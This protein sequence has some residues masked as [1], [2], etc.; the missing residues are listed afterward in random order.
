MGKNVCP[1]TG[2]KVC[3]AHLRAEPRNLNN[4]GKPSFV[5]K[6]VGVEAVT[7]M[8]RAPQKA[9][10]ASLPCVFWHHSS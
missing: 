7:V 6:V 3:P 4:M 1:Q 2:I 9:V 10:R 5:P 8:E